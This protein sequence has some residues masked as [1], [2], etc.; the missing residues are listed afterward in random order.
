[1]IVANR[2]IDAH[3][4]WHT[5]TAARAGLGA[6]RVV[7]AAIPTRI[8]HIQAP[9]H[10]AKLVLKIGQDLVYRIAAT[11]VGR[12]VATIQTNNAVIPAIRNIEIIWVWRANGP[13]KVTFTGS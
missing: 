3:S 8:L 4:I 5:R 6:H 13:L 10:A 7:G 2:L 12:H 11:L 1:M 9:E